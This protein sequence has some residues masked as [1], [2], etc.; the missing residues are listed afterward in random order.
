MSYG[1]AR[2]LPPAVAAAA[3]AAE[4]ETGRAREP[5]EAESVDGA[6]AP[7]AS[8]RSRRGGASDVFRPGGASDTF[9]R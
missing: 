9:R 8:G 3:G 2:D 6:A 4:S 1:D 5:W 7:G